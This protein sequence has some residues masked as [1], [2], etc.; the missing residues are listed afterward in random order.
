MAGSQPSPLRLP[1]SLSRL[2]IYI[3]LLFHTKAS[4]EG[5]RPSSPAADAPDQVDP[6]VPNYFPTDP[7]ALCDLLDKVARHLQS[8]LPDCEWLEEGEIKFT[9]VRPVDVG[10]VA[11][12]FVGMRENRKVAVKCYRFYQSS[13]YLPTYMV[14]KLD[15]LWVRPAH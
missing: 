10:E 2:F 7:A 8:R 5:A 14:R 13:D 12:I 11:D 9:T 15:D 3:R 4:P 6:S 1:S